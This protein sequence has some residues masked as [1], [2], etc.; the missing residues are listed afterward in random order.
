MKKKLIYLLFTLSFLSVSCSKEDEPIQE[1]PSVENPDSEVDTPEDKT[2]VQHVVITAFVDSKFT[3]PSGTRCEAEFYDAS[4]NILDCEKTLA[5]ASEHSFNIGAKLD[6][7][8]QYT[9]LLWFDNGQYGYD[10]SEGLRCIRMSTKPALAF[11]G[12]LSFNSDIS[13]YELEMKPA[14]AQVILKL[15]EHMQTGNGLFSFS[16]DTPVKYVFDVSAGTV[17]STDAVYIPKTVFLLNNIGKVAELYTFVP[18]GGMNVNL[19]VDYDGKSSVIEDVMLQK[20]YATTLEGD[21][22]N[23]TFSVT[24]TSDIQQD[25]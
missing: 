7:G 2:E 5:A 21:I 19:R 1:N 8:K 6:K 11:Y 10:I 24:A 17:V 22:E 18:D 9:C 23:M 4:G 3:L 16:E 20:G 12:K 25:L 13:K 15:K 14:V